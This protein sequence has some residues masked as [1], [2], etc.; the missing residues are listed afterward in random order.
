MQN[1]VYNMSYNYKQ[2][3]NIICLPED[4]S[5]Q[6]VTSECYNQLLCAKY[7]KIFSIW[8]CSSLHTIE[9][10]LCIGDSDDLN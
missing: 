5:S 2:G 1:N 8:K 10:D 9:D 7:C 6:S 4:M 3:H